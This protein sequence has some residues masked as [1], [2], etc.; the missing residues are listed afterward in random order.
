LAQ[1]QNDK[2]V[3]EDFFFHATK[4][5]FTCFKQKK[6]AEIYREQGYK[7]RKLVK[8]DVGGYRVNEI[9]KK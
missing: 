9:V 5:S 4:H 3:E 2:T 7:I 8:T 1:H 6:M